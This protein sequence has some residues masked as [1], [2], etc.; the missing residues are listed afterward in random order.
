MC[1]TAIDHLRNH[2]LQ[3][4]EY[5]RL[6]TGVAFFFFDFKR[7]SQ[8][9]DCDMLRSLLWQLSEGLDDEHKQLRELHASKK[10]LTRDVLS[11][12]LHKIM[13]KF[14]KVFILIDALDE[15]PMIEEE[16]LDESQSSTVRATVLSTIKVIRNW[17]LPCLHLLVTSR[18]LAD[19]RDSLNPR[20]D[21]IVIMKNAAIQQDIANYIGDVLQ[22][23]FTLRRYKERRREIQKLISERSQCA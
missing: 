15:S 16:A 2:H 1:A 6:R 18:D 4:R 13:R 12:C 14:S 11:D 20:Q 7:S 21:Q 5:V 23:H 9:D 22:A 8:Q 17:N 10:A 19:I 3:Q